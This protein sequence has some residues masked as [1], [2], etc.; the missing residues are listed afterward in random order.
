MWTSSRVPAVWPCY[1]PEPITK[2]GC[3][4]P[5]QYM[6]AGLDSAPPKKRVVRVWDLGPAGHNF[7]AH[8]SLT[9]GQTSPF[10]I[11]ENS[12]NICGSSLI[13]L[14]APHTLFFFSL[15]LYFFLAMCSICGLLLLNANMSC[16]VFYLFISIWKGSIKIKDKQGKWHRKFLQ[17]INFFQKYSLM[18]ESGVSQFLDLRDIYQRQSW[19]Y[20]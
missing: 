7:Y 8:S 2:P 11:S 10:S 19:K 9:F 1:W 6:L 13:Y 15:C 14:W 4:G 18:P 20:L 5:T 12:K 16:K 17:Q 3:L